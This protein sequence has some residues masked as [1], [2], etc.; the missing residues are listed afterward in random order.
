[1]RQHG[2]RRIKTSA[3]RR[4]EP[5]ETMTATDAPTASQTEPGADDWSTEPT[6]VITQIHDA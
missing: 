1:M 6:E 5:D 2:R 3:D 4:A